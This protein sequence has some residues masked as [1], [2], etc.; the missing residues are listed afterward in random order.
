LSAAAAIGQRHAARHFHVVLQEK[1]FDGIQY[2]IGCQPA[3][4]LHFKVYLIHL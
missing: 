1:G 2:V 4:T 3:V